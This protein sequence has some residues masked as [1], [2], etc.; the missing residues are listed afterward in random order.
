MHG[1]LS[2]VNVYHFK[3]GCKY[4]LRVHEPPFICVWRLIAVEATVNFLE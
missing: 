3:E 4:T 2:F 1:E